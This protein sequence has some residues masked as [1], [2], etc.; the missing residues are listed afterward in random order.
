[1]ETT[2]QLTVEPQVQAAGTKAQE[3]YRYAAELYRQQSDWVTF[4]RKVLGVE[5][6]ARR[7]FPSP[8]EMLSLEQ[9][10]EYDDIQLML[11]KLRERGKTPPDASEPTRVITVRL[12]KSLH[13][14]LRTEAHEKRT[15]MNKL[16]IS[17]LLQ[18]VDGE[19]IPRD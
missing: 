12:P 18:M 1:M 7:L 3:V 14:S 8:S 13:E 16:C 15:S 9:S 2:Q 4:F 5:G 6:V 10:K 11:A 17:K 19:L